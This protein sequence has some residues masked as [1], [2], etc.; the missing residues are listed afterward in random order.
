[1]WQMGR[2]LEPVGRQVRGLEAGVCVGGVQSSACCLGDS[3]LKKSGFRDYISFIFTSLFVSIM[4]RRI[5]F[6]I[7]LL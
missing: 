4:A 3:P 5:Y 2:Y 7:S 6:G 1:M